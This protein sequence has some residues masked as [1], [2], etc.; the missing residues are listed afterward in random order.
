MSDCTYISKSNRREERKVDFAL[1]TL[2]ESS[3]PEKNH[4]MV[5]KEK[6]SVCIVEN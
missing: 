1:E 2:I 6:K 3:S 5:A 4:F